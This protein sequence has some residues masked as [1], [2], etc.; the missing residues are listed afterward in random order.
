MCV[1]R[2]EQM[3]MHTPLRMY[4]LDLT[5]FYRSLSAGCPA[6][7]HK[8]GENE[9]NVTKTG[10]HTCKIAC[11]P[12][13][14]CATRSNHCT[15]LAFM[16]LEELAHYREPLL[17]TAARVSPAVLHRRTREQFAVFVYTLDGKFSRTNDLLAHIPI[18]YQNNTMQLHQHECT[19]RQRAGNQNGVHL[20]KTK[21]KS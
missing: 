3:S 10:V 20:H 13:R 9:A 2:S 8:M 16:F 18:A 11:D 4:R 19:C 7:L 15:D 12:A 21:M 14:L 17:R 6:L 5:R 1:Q